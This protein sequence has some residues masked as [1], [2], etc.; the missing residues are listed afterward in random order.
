MMKLLRQ[1]RVYPLLATVLLCSH[2]TVLPPELRNQRAASPPPTP[3]QITHRQQWL[4]QADLSHAQWLLDRQK[5]LD[6]P[7]DL[8]PSQQQQAQRRLYKEQQ[9]LAARL[10]EHCQALSASATPL[11]LTQCH[12]LLHKLPLDA[13][14]AP[15]LQHLTKPKFSSIQ[16]TTRNT[17]TPTPSAMPS[18]TNDTLLIIN[19]PGSPTVDTIAASNNE[20]E[21][22]KK[23]IATADLLQQCQQNAQRGKWQ[24][25]RQQLN[26]LRDREDLTPPSSKKIDTIELKLRHTLDQMESRAEL[27]Y[28]DKKIADAQRIWLEILQIDPDKQDIRNKYQRAQTVLENIEVLRQQPGKMP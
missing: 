25:V 21:S 6:M 1:T 2:C 5:L 18:K 3:Q 7:N 26:Q 14:L 15:Q 19:A 11:L 23:I 16:P 9:Q 20:L 22:N 17:P 13:A 28:Q 27:L 4:A 10:L 24:Q 12:H 8:S